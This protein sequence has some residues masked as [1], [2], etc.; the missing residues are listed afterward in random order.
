MST[1]D[2]FPCTVARLKG[3]AFR[4]PHYGEV[5]RTPDVLR[6]EMLSVVFGW[7]DDIQSLIRDELARHRVGSASGVLLSKWLGDIRADDMA[8]MIGS[9]SMT[10]SDWM[11]LALSSIGS[12]SK[13][14][15]GEAFV[16][17]LLEKGDIHPAVAI[18]LGLGEYN[19]AIEVYVSQQYCMEAVLLTALTCPSDWG[20]IS[21]LLR[22]WG[23]AAVMSGEAELAVR[24][25]SCTSIETTA[26]WTSPQAQDAVHVAQQERSAVPRSAVDVASPTFSIPSA[27]PSGRLKAK[28]ASLK[29]I[30]NFGDRGAPAQTAGGPSSALDTAN[31]TAGVTPILTSALPMSPGGLD[32]WKH[33]TGRLARDPASART[34]TPGGVARR[35]RLPSRDDIERA[36]QEAAEMA[37][38]ITAARDFGTVNAPRTTSR[39]SNSRPGG[40]GRTS[41]ASSMAEPTTALR[42]TMYDSEQLA[43]RTFGESMDHLPSPAQ[44]VFTRFR[45]GSRQRNVSRERKPEHLAVQVLDTV[46]TDQPSPEPDTGIVSPG[47][48]FRSG[49]LSPP[50]TGGSSKASAKGR[51]TDRFKSSVE[52]ARRAAKRDRAES[53]KRG[54]SRKRDQSRSGRASNRMREASESRTNAGVQYIRPAKRSPSSPVPM[55]PAEIARAS[56]MQKADPATTDDE[57]FYKVGLQSPVE[58]QPS[59]RSRGFSRR[60]DSPGNTVAVEEDLLPFSPRQQSPKRNDSRGRSERRAISSTTRSPSAPVS[61][62]SDKAYAGGVDEQAEDVTR[63]RLR[64]KSANRRV[65]EDLQSRRL[66][67]RDR[68][69]RSASRRPKASDSSVVNASEITD[70]IPEEQASQSSRASESSASVGRPRGMSRKELAAKELEERRRSLARRPSAP[71]IPLPGA[72]TLGTAGAGALRPA[73]APRSQTDLGD[74]PTSYNSQMSRG[75]TFEADA[76]SKYISQSKITG[77]STPSAPIGL[78]ATPR[79]MRHPRYMSTDPNEREDMPPVPDIPGKFSDLGS[80]SGSNLSQVTES[81]VSQVSSSLLSTMQQKSSMWSSSNSRSLLSEA[82]D[83]VGP[84]LPSTVYGQQSSNG[85]L[86]SARSASAPPQDSSPIHPL[87]R[88]AQPPNRRLSNVRKI[89]PPET[90]T[91]EG[92]ENIT[93]IDAAL[94]GGDN[95]VII[96]PDVS[97]PAPPMLPELQHLAMPPPPPPPPLRIPRL[98]SLGGSGMIN[99]AIGEKSPSSAV[100]NYSQSLPQPMERASTASPAQHR[101][102]Q[103]SGGD[104]SFGSRIRG[105]GDRMRSSSKNRTKSPTL[106]FKPSPYESVLPPYIP[107]GSNHQRRESQEQN[108]RAQSPYEQA[109]AAQGQ[110]QGQ[111]PASPAS[112]MRATIPSSLPGSRSGSTTGG[113]RHPKDVRAN[114]PPEYIQQGALPGNNGFL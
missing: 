78:P 51:A 114:M 38:P 74:S 10:S 32:P 68:R 87:Y 46:Y 29:L 59:A 7:H 94:Y 24:C 49:T 64:S 33:R 106:E 21:Y 113:Y 105:I 85:S 79:A 77:T 45:E 82:S 14:K 90:N 31:M 8:S 97:E 92:P 9:E 3:V 30:T 67:S 54:E 76:V 42:P 26:P 88:S 81:N 22:K 17:R 27:S 34:A 23:E 96:V 25:F 5:A 35:K 55:S 65:M 108:R 58:S 89:S 66:A 112:G 103:P 109:M 2:L 48:A 91:S 80:L 63:L 70:I 60:Q 1:L 41:S 39:S 62:L 15:V 100:D 69:E 110:T 83:S 13:K 56:Q 52:E 47:G 61:L 37:T 43:P 53:R 111:A 104:S 107:G 40:S 36:K 98:G 4:T 50:L 11:L 28:N 18:L 86:G 6:R 20:R 99:I 12:E 93:S 84:L 19:D 57:E 16:Q 75:Y 102:N 95:Q 101:R 73:M 71:A 44:G 72:I